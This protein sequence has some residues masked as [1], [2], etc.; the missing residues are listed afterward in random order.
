MLG[1][2]PDIDEGSFV[3]RQSTVTEGNK[4]VKIG[5]PVYVVEGFNVIIMCKPVGTPPI[6]IQWFRNGPPDPTRGNVSR[7]TINDANNGDIFKCRA[8]NNI[9]FDM[10]SSTI[11]IVIVHSKWIMHV[12]TYVCKHACMYKFI[13]TTHS[14]RLRLHSQQL[15]QLM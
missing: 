5:S 4:K 13:Y 11:H 2:P 10:E 7:I 14:T 9:G 12:L 8:D 3:S 1:N 15:L 6:T